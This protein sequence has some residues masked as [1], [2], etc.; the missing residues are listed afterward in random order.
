MVVSYQVS[1]ILVDSDFWWCAVKYGSKLFRDSSFVPASLAP[2]LQKVGKA[3]SATGRR[4]A[5][6]LRLASFGIT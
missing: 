5:L 2:A 6:V 4:E 1:A 3:R